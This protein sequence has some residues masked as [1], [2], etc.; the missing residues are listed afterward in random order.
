M[1]ESIHNI[2]TF[3]IYLKSSKR[4]HIKF[5]VNKEKIPQFNFAIEAIY[6]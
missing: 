2:S 6:A 1:T 3:D 5:K 4:E